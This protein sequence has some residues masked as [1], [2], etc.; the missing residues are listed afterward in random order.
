[1][2]QHPENTRKPRKM[3]INTE[4][5]EGD[6][7]KVGWSKKEQ[8]VS[9]KVIR[10]GQG[11]SARSITRTVFYERK[12]KPKILN[13]II[14][15]SSKNFSVSDEQAI[16]QY[17]QVWS[18]DTNTKEVFGYKLNITGI[19]ALNPEGTGEIEEIAL[20]FSGGA[21]GSSE[22][23]NL[24][25]F[26][27]FLVHNKIVNEGEEYA[28]IMD[29]EFGKK[30]KYNRSEEPIYAN[31]CLPKN[32]TLLYATAD[33]GQESQLIK[34]IR[35]SDRLATRAFEGIADDPENEEFFEE[36]RSG[37]HIQAQLE[38]LK[39]RVEQ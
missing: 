27:K 2:A 30:D 35:A 16:R 24:A 9:I 36:G 5:E 8:R 12:N 10:D 19:C 29:A 6:S 33:S 13:Q 22:L 21:E 39:E 7:I 4:V 26:L 17:R 31:F 34:A 3:I 25:L 32:F 14:S 28:I 15:Y 38:F 23:Y 11:V 1:M 37:K 18:V 20:L